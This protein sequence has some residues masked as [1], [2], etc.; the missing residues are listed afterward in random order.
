MSK[1]F[2]TSLVRVYVGV[3]AAYDCFFLLSFSL[4]IS[5]VSFVSIDFFL[6]SGGFCGLL[7]FFGSISSVSSSGIE[8]MGSCLWGRSWRCTWLNSNLVDFRTTFNGTDLQSRR[9]SVG[10]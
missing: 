3:S 7:F 2:L 6:R 4:S 5:L 1:Y 9:A 8:N 10:S